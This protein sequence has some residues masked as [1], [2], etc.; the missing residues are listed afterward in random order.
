MKELEK[1]LAGLFAK[2]PNLPVNIKQVI[3]KIAPY[4]AVIGVILSLPAV[5]ALIGLGAIGSSIS[6]A[7][8]AWGYAGSGTLAVAFATVSVVLMALAIKG[9]FARTLSGWQ[10]MYYN[11]L[12]GGV[13]SLIRVDIMSF[14]IGTG[15]SLYLLFQVKSYYR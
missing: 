1:M 9:L 11:A 4:L 8:G 6:A 15:V 2:L 3:V 7:S 13:Y 10:F 5:L 12:V 14:I